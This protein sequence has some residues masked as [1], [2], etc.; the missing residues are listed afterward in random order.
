[1]EH[2]SCTAAEYHLTRCCFPY[3]LAMSQ[4]FLYGEGA[5][6]VLLD[7]PLGPWKTCT[8]RAGAPNRLVMILTLRCPSRPFGGSSG[9]Q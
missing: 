4:Y 7:Q 5:C 9:P 1:M 2:C 6:G 3:R 8:L